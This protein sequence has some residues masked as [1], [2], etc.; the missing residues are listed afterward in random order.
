MDVLM[1][2]I[3]GTLACL[4]FFFICYSVTTKQLIRDQ[5]K[6]IAKLSTE[7]RRLKSALAGARY[8]EHLVISKEPA[9]NPKATVKKYI[10]PKD[11]TW[12]EDMQRDA[13]C[14]YESLAESEEEE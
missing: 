14:Y 8:V 5:E 12:A 4:I 6:E 2:C 9:N 10:M 7:N 11:E 13:E 1:I 3:F